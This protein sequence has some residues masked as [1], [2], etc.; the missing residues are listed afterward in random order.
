MNID[1][2]YFPKSYY[3]SKPDITGSF[4]FALDGVTKY[5]FDF[6]GIYL[7][8]CDDD[9]IPSW[10]TN[11]KAF[12][13]YSC[14]E[15]DSYLQDEFEQIC[16]ASGI[17]FRCMEQRKGSSLF[18][19]EIENEKQLKAI[20]P[21][22]ITQG[23]SNELVVWSSKKNVF[24]L[25]NREWTGVHKGM[26]KKTVVVKMEEDTSVFWIGHDGDSIATISNQL[27]FSSY[28]NISQTLPEFVIPTL[29]EYAETDEI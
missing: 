8:E 22:Y 15:V 2:G 12:P 14:V 9:F 28:E 1:V 21:L 17:R 5:V 4:P 20:F 6:S 11:V 13:I 24:S 16:N 19:S 26:I 7:P 10:M 27:E 18:V 29:I 3:D 23:T 25:E